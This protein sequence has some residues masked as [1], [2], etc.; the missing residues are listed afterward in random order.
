MDRNFHYLSKY[1]LNIHKI[2]ITMGLHRKNK[3]SKDSF[4]RDCLNGRGYTRIHTQAY[5]LIRTYRKS[6]TQ[7]LGKY[8]PANLNTQKHSMNISIN[9]MC[10]NSCTHTIENKQKGRD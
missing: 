1:L 7:L 8:I 5:T 9:H 10:M 2:C 3:K 6:T 4:F